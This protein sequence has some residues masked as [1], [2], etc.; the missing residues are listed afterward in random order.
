MKFQRIEPPHKL[1]SLVECYWIVTN[2]SMKYMLFLILAISSTGCIGQTETSANF[3][4]LGWLTG[5]WNRTNIS[6]PGKT[7]YEVWQKVGDQEIRGHGAVLQGQDIVFLQKFS[8]LVKDNSIYYVADVP[9]NKQ[10]V[11]FKLME[12][13]DSGFVC[14]NPKHDF[15]KK[16]TYQ[17][18]GVNLKAQISGNGK[19]FDYLFKRPE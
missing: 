6:K 4:K 5:T 13:T 3:K 11:Y 2:C 9:E 16:I 7:A 1:K 12:I 19:S 10:P 14:E 18:Y 17:L 8:I 15:P